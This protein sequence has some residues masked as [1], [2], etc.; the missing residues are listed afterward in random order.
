MRA[1]LAQLVPAIT[2]AV[3][4]RRTPQQAYDEVLGVLE[5]DYADAGPPSPSDRLGTLARRCGLTD[6]QTA[7]LVAAV[8]PS[9][10]STM[11]QAYDLLTGRLL[12]GQPTIAIALE[13]SALPSADGVSARLLHPAGKLRRVGLLEVRGEEG[14]LERRLVVPDRVRAFLTGDDIADEAV[15]AVAVDAMPYS[16]P[17]SDDL[18]RALDAGQRLIW[19]QS[20]PG[21][22]GTSLAV[23]GLAAAGLDCLVIDARLAPATALAQTLRAAVREATLRGA[24]LV[25]VGADVVVAPAGAELSTALAGSPVPVIAVGTVAWPA[26]RSAEAPLTVHAPHVTS[27]DRTEL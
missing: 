24:G 22:A 16:R 26:H 8:A 18:A 19:V 12:H 13:L 10:D 25:V 23:S 27:A 11:A 3:A 7:L 14:W 1:R 5:R 6:E 17:R 15:L 9:L 2:E 21:A 4:R 20:P